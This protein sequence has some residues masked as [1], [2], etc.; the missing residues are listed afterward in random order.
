MPRVSVALVVATCCASIAIFGKG[1]ADELARQESKPSIDAQGNAYFENK[2]RP[3]LV[4]RC[5]RCHGPGS[6]EGKA[7]LRVDSRDALLRGGDSGPAIVPGEPENSLLIL[8]IRHDGAISM[9]PKSKLPQAEIDALTAWVKMGAPWPHYAGKPVVTTQR[10]VA[11][12]WSA[13]ER[14]FWA[15]QPPGSEPLRPVIGKAW[16]RS[17]IDQIILARLEV[18]ALQPAPASEKRALI[19]RATLDLCGIP[20][21]RDEIDD[22]LHDESPA[23]LARVVDRLLASPRHGE[24]WGR[25]WLDVARYADSNGMDDNL[26]YSDAWRYRDYVVASLNADKPY[27]AFVAEQIAGDLIARAEPARRDT[28][29]IATG[30]L[31]LGPKM[32]AEDDPVKQ[33]MD[34]VDEQLDTTCRAFLALTMGC[35]AVTTTSST[36]SRSAITTRWRGFSRARA[37]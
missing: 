29:I 12:Q 37:R 8:A 31:A 28:L 6:G 20:P 36:R 13:K 19:R 3:I 34:I 7:N 15:F 18:A 11:R 10:S 21:S 35:A 32:L 17:R 9:P 14:S 23:A 25:H 24:R 27:D 2:V 4:A 22:F 1:V 5:D 33:Q 26:A 16:P 30:F